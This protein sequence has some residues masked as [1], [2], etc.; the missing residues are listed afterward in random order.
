MQSISS[1]AFDAVRPK[2]E[3]R[4]AQAFRPGNVPKENRPERAADYG[5]LFPKKTFVKSKSMAFQKLTNLFPVRKSAMMFGLSGNVGANS[6]Y[7]RLGWCLRFFKCASLRVDFDPNFLTMQE[8]PTNLSSKRSYAQL[9]AKGL[10]PSALRNKLTIRFK[11]NPDSAALSGRFSLYAVP[12]PEGLGDLLFAL[13][14]IG[15]RSRNVQT[16]GSAFG[17]VW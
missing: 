1:R 17:A 8:R 15:T 9:A 13:R 2:G 7:F 12:R 6:L 4:T 10:G 5:A 11:F 14:A 16:R 3:N